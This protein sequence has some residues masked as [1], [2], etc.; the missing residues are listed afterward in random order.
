MVRQVKGRVEGVTK[1]PLKMNWGKEGFQRIAYPSQQAGQPKINDKL[2][3]ESKSM[4]ADLKVDL[5]AK[6]K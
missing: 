4:I 1:E 6:D 5:E 2:S 3:E